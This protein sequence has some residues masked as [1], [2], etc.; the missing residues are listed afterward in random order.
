M[1]IDFRVRPPLPGFEKLS[2]LGPTK[3]FETFPFNY[4]ENRE[5]PS[6]RE[7]S[8]PMFIREMDEA[9][10]SKGVVLPRS[11]GGNLGSLSNDEVASGVSLYP[12]RLI[13][14]GVID[15]SAGFKGGD[16]GRPA[17]ATSGI[18]DAVREVERAISVL[19][20]RGI[21]ME[22]G[23]MSPALHPDSAKLYPVYDRCAE[24][25]VPVVI[26]Q[27]M[28]LGP[29]LSFANPE[30]VQHAARDFPEC[31]FII[32]HAG[33]PWVLAADAV[34]CVCDNVYIIPDIYAHMPDV[35]GS[36]L[37]GHGI[38]F[39]QGKRFLF[40]SAYPVRGMKQSVEDVQRFG[41]TERQYR[42]YTY[43]NAAELL[44]L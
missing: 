5:I 36:G 28:Y 22:P 32:A 19:G 43:E 35:A 34:A 24:L 18:R 7:M 8:M 42:M 30:C 23:C 1:I 14:F 9:G 13:G 44:N 20:L 15:V 31:K 41:L 16:D 29:D 37:Y 38:R 17:T 10:I 27:S 6:A 21:V 12:D 33:Y 4:A 3:G 26:S 40:A 11:I 39:T 25:G 2:I